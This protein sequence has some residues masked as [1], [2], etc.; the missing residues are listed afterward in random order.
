MDQD[1]SSLE[2]LLLEVRGLE[3]GEDDW[4]VSDGGIRGKRVRCTVCY[5]S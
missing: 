2:P 4:E 3:R 5:S 1:L